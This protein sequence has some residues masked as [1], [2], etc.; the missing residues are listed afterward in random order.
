METSDSD[1]LMANIS[2]LATT[3]KAI[4]SALPALPCAKIA[5]ELAV[6]VESLRQPANSSPSDE[7]MLQVLTAFRDL[8]SAVSRQG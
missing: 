1:R 8:A 6:E 4:I 5:M 7:T 2:A 3:L